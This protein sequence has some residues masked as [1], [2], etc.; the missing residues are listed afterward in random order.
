MATTTDKA[1]DILVTYLTSSSFRPG[2]PDW[3]LYKAECKSIEKVLRIVSKHNA[4][5]NRKRAERK[6]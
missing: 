5:Q 6:R 2:D 1:E 4:K 3:P